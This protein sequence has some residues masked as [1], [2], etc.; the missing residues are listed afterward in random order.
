VGLAL[1]LNLGAPKAWAKTGDFQKILTSSSISK[2]QLGLY[3]VKD[4]KAVFENR[5]QQKMVP[6]SLS[7][8]LTAITVL[9]KFAPE[10]RFT[11]ELKSDAKIKDGVLDG[12]L[13][14]RGNGDS[15]FISE[16]MWV[17]VNNFTRNK[18]RKIN[19][20]LV[21]DSTN[22]DDKYFDD[23][24]EDIRVDR[25]Y[26]SPVSGLPFNW[27]AV[28]VYVRPNGKGALIVADPSD[29]YF[30]IV[31]KVRLT[32]GSR[33]EITVSKEPLK[34]GEKLIVSGTIGRD[35]TEVVKY[36]SI[37]YPDLWVGKNLISFL[38]DRGIE[39]DNQKIVSKKC[40]D[41]APTLAIAKGWTV[42][43]ILDGM[44]KYSNN[45][46]AE[47]FT[48]Q[49]AVDAGAGSGN[50][51]KG[52]EV[53]RDTLEKE[54]GLSK[55][56]YDF[57]NPSGF[58]NKN[59]ISAQALGNLLWSAYKDFTVSSYLLSDLATPLSE[60]TLSKRMKGL[61]KPRL[62]HAKTGLLAG[63]VGLAGYAADTKG[64]VYSFVFIYNG[65]GKEDQARD[66]FDRMAME[67]TKL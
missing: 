48:K 19:G 58:T 31:N 29:G 10:Q 24:R 33:A 27:N 44:L 35:S 43:E 42:N 21:V 28:N 30:E 25:A 46:L 12:E 17:L 5:A 15:T 63:V 18:I 59:K 13:C 38:K 60:G 49:L 54:Y 51:A 22:F 61:D 47:S 36:A 52:V 23:S 56:D 2:D 32:S 9:K 45:F 64:E 41:S 34:H 37:S 55:K 8:L 65:S 26:D 4:Q 7:K 16:Q 11:T 67:I 40:S 6:A 66:L 57:V 14:I 39:F 20:P 3:I 50:I 62:V 1:S 53:I